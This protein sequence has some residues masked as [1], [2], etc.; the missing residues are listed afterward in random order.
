MKQT[1]VTIAALVSGALVAASI[2]WISD[3]THPIPIEV[4]NEDNAQMAEWIKTLPI[5]ALLIVL[6]SWCA[7]GLI[8]GYVARRLSPNRNSRPGIIAS[9]L[10][11]VATILKLMMSPHPLWLWFAGI[12][13]CLAFGVIGL[14]LAAPR[15]YTVRASRTIGS[16]I[17]N[18]FGTLATV[19]NFA[20][21]VPHITKVEFL[22]EKKQGQ[23]TR[24]CETRMMNGKES[25]TELEITEF[26]EN[27]LVRYL[28][29]AGGTIWDTIFQVEEAEVEEAEV[30]ESENQ[31]E[32]S[33]RMEA[34]PKSLFAKILVPLILGAIS[35]AVEDDMDSIKE[36]CEKRRSILT[37]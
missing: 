12:G 5:G 34:I 29:E 18:V 28:S 15:S 27:R 25:M 13:G 11:T 26:A 19:E 30:E 31:T 10:L 9:G 3:A 6:F 20:T 8:A 35:K 33:M 1:P 2:Q 17:K 7:G 14:L 24:F 22:S 23:G 4:L 21:A 32:M 37:I 36:Y 16:P